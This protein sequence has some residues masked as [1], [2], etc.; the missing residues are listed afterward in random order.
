MIIGAKYIRLMPS[1]NDKQKLN[2]GHQS[3]LEVIQCLKPELK[4]IV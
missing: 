3:T 1:R 2:I 4:Q